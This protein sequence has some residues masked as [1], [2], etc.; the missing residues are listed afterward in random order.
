MARPTPNF[1]SAAR[2]VTDWARLFVSSS[3][4]LLILFRSFQI[5]CFR[6]LQFAIERLTNPVSDTGED[7]LEETERLFSVHAVIMGDGH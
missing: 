2:R 3:N 7:S 1:C 6:G 4:L 5:V